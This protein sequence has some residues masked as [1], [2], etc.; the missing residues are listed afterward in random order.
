MCGDLNR[1]GLLYGWCMDGLGVAA[2]SHERYCLERW[3]RFRGWA[4]YVFLILFP[5][6]LFFFIDLLFQIKVTSAPMN[7]FVFM[8]QFNSF[9]VNQ[10]PQYQT[11][12]SL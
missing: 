12:G 8:A 7:F 9:I 10:A 5:P 6:T 3:I 4:L 1:T 2:S 11:T